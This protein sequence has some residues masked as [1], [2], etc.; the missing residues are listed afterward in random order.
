MGAVVDVHLTARASETRAT[1]AQ[2]TSTQIHTLTAISTR[3]VAAAVQSLLTVGSSKGWGTAADVA[4][5]EFFL[6]RPSVK[7]GVIRTRH[8]NDLTVLPIESLRTCAGVII[9]QIVATATILAG[10]AITLV[11][12]QLTVCA[13]ISW[14]AGAGIASLSGVGAGGAISTGFVVGA[15]VEVLV[16]EEASPALL[17]HTLPWLRAG[18]M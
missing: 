15:V 13:P 10:V 7:A 16:T 14:P 4:T 3:F 6:T 8:C 1:V 5:S 18:P 12:L 9:L 17:T 11:N 2:S